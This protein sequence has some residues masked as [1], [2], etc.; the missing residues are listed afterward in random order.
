MELDSHPQPEQECLRRARIHIQEVSGS[1]LRAGGSTV[2]S[3]DTK[4]SASRE[5]QRSDLLLA[6]LS[7]SEL[8]G[9][10]TAHGAGLSL[11]LAADCIYNTLRSNQTPFCAC[12]REHNR[13][14]FH[15]SWVIMALCVVK[16]FHDRKYNLWAAHSLSVRVRL[17]KYINI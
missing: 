2:A 15:F 5:K 13:N 9:I 7:Y 16:R 11:D 4:H 17:Y 6:P 12:D 3:A 8:K 1:C 10:H 14:M